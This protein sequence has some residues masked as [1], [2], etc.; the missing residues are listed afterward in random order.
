MKQYK[1]RLEN[2]TPK[3]ITDVNRKTEFKSRF[4]FKGVSTVQ[5]NHQLENSKPAK[6]C[7]QNHVNTGLFQE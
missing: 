2:R 6:Y 4:K 7:L 5:E 1:T 3:K